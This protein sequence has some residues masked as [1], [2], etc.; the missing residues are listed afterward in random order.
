MLLIY[1][2]PQIALSLFKRPVYYEDLVDKNGGKEIQIYQTFF[3]IFNSICT[4]LLMALFMDYIIFKY[5]YTS[6]N[7]FELIGVIGG[8]FGLFKKWQL[9]CGSFLMKLMILCK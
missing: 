4:S 1:L 7:Y 9:I 8:I 2:C 5:N 3:F 6:L